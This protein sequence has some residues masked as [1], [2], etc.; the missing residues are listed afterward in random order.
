MKKYK[1][2]ERKKIEELHEK[3]MIR[4]RRWERREK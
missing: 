1:E 3:R 2:N 4:E